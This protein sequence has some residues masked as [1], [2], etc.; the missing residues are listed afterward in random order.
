MLS[1][2]QLRKKYFQIRKRNY[3]EVSN[4]FY[5]PLIKLLSTASN[6]K[7]VYLS[8]YY[9]SAYE[10]NTLS[11]LN[12][13]S[14][15]KN[16]ISLLPVVN[17]N[18]TMKFFKWAFPDILR[19]N[20]YGM[21]EPIKSKKSLVPNVALVPLL[22]YDNEN[23]RLGYGKGYY[24]KFLNKY[25]KKNKNILTIGV[26]FSFQKYNKL[27]KSKFDVKLDYILTEKGIT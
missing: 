25:L 16:I 9:P 6:K 15:K 1:K 5:S 19:V 8:I 26:A 12:L 11:L 14:K 10:V 22:A 7:L 3:F 20:K 18:N 17:S 24:D 13:I 2:K 23:Y 4:S 21:L 27:P